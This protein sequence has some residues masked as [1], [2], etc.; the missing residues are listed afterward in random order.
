M[1]L[2]QLINLMTHDTSL[3]M[4]LFSQ[5]GI[6]VYNR[7]YIIES[8]LAYICRCS[9]NF[10]IISF[11]GIDFPIIEE[12]VLENKSVKSSNKTQI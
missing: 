5:F 10:C 2:S 1:D 12:Y 3:L 11:N 6:I 7:W 4:L 8:W 9:V